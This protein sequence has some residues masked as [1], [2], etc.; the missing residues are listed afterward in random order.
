MDQVALD[1]FD[2]GD[3]LGTQEGT[4]RKKLKRTD[5]LAAPGVS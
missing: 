1:Q 4:Q 2:E 3:D 5:E